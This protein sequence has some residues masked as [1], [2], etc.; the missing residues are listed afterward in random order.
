MCGK[1]EK[2]EIGPINYSEKQEVRNE[3]EKTIMELF[4]GG[5][6]TSGSICLGGRG[7]SDP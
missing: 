5:M 7:N 6:G 2:E 1:Y 3:K 4:S